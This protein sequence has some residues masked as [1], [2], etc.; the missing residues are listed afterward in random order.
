MFGSD[1]DFDIGEDLELII[2]SFV[3]IFERVEIGVAKEDGL[4]LIVGAFGASECSGECEKVVVG[5]EIG[6]FEMVFEGIWA[7]LV[8]VG[9]FIVGV[10]SICVILVGI[11]EILLHS[12]EIGVTGEETERSDG[13]SVVFRE[14]RILESDETVFFVVCFVRAD[15]GEIVVVFEEEEGED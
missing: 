11:C 15:F 1:F 5:L 9:V 10:F 14:I 13:T 8:L 6:L 12:F 7:R 3:V 4:E 2:D